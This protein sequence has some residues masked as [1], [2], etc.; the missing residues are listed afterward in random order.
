[1]TETIEVV[2]LGECLVSF[3]AREQGPLA[4]VADF[5]RYVAGAEANV[6]VGLARLGHRAAFIGRIGDDSFGTA[7]VRRLRGDGVDTRWLRVEP[8]ARTGL[9]FRERRGAGPSEVVYHR[10]GSA[11]S[12]LGPE[13]VQ[14]AAAA[15]V[16]AGARL[17]HLTGITPALSA[18]CRA[19]VLAAI[20]GAQANGLSIAL[21]INLRRRLWSDA[22]AAEVLRPLLASVDIVFG[23]LDEG[24]VLGGTSDDAGPQIV[25]AALI[26]SGAGHAVLK[27]GADGAASLASDGTWTVVPAVAGVTVVDPVGA[28]DAFCA[29]YLAGQLEG[30][31]EV[32]AL[33]LG[34]A[35]GAAV[36]AVEG[37]Q[38]GAPTREEARLIGRTGADQAIR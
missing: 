35:C 18:S 16:F 3:V 7:I 33:A 27:L 31:N 30:L 17:L 5:R 24:I 23:S 38:A 2:T 12:R 10:A 6:A 1:V 14:A 13:D 20:E 28:G 8:D 32:D 22:D 25:A 29:G 9:M 4:E 34:N 15:G 37:D 26:G 19:A 11:G 36:V 21:D